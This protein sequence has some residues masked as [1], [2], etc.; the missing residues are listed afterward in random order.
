MYLL[1]LL[2]NFYI[3]SISL[4]DK[5]GI[6]NLG[7]TIDQKDVEKLPVQCIYAMSRVSYVFDQSPHSKWSKQITMSIGILL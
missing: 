1:C 6:H 2:F 4:P 7:C 5:Y 3:Q